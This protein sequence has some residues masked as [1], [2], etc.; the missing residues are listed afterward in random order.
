MYKI[1]SEVNIV[2]SL[3]FALILP[4]SETNGDYG[5]TCCEKPSPAEIPNS[6]RPDEFSSSSAF[7]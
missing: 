1:I 4:P 3:L 6:W 2:K 5:A 7:A